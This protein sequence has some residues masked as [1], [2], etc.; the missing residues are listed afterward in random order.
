MKRTILLNLFELSESVLF[1]PIHDIDMAIYFNPTHHKPHV[2]ILKDDQ[3]EALSADTGARMSLWNLPQAGF[4]RQVKVSLDFLY[5]GV[6]R[7][8]KNLEIRSL[9]DQGTIYELVRDKSRSDSILGFEW[10]FPGELIV[11]SSTGIQFY[12]VTCT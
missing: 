3:M 11:F 4:I 2:L 12:N 6:L 8:A 5:I 9:F 10:S 7:S 1:T